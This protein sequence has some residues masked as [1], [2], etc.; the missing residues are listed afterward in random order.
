MS[1][2]GP[3]WQHIDFKHGDETFKAM[4]EC[5][6]GCV[7]ARL[8]SSKTGAWSHPSTTHHIPGYRPN[9]HSAHAAA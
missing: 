3:D 5:S 7:T 2:K 1:E 8:F 4:Y 9:K 6:D